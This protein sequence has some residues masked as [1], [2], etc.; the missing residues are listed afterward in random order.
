[1]PILF[2]NWHRRF[3][4]FLP[5]FVK[6]AIPI[7]YLIQTCSEVLQGINLQSGIQS[8]ESHITTQTARRQNA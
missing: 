6:F 4:Q 8:Y 2:G 7:R 5:K 3:E 1:M